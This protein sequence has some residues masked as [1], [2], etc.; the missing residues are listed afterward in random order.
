MGNELYEKERSVAWK[1]TQIFE[2]RA[3]EVNF[4][5]DGHASYNTVRGDN[6]VFLPERSHYYL[7]GSC[8]VE[9]LCGVS[10]GYN[11]SGSERFRHV[12]LCGA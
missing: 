2:K 12:G 9:A 10:I 1:V 3:A 5:H 6:T 11:E 7:P 8:Q 4:G